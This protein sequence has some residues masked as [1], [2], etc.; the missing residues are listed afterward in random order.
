MHV[1][2]FDWALGYFFPPLGKPEWKA[3]LLAQAA[4]GKAL[5]ALLLFDLAALALGAS[6]ARFMRFRSNGGAMGLAVT[7]VLGYAAAGTA[8]AAV[9]LAGLAYPSVYA[10]L[11]LLGLAFLLRAPVMR[12]LGGAGTALR[13]FPAGVA[14]PALVVALGGLL[15]ALAP[16][17]TDDALRL[18]LGVP[19]R[20]LLVHRLVADPLTPFSFVPLLPCGVNLPLVALS[21]DLPARLLN[22]QAWLVVGLVVFERVSRGGNGARHGAGRLVGALAATAW[23]ALLNVPAVAQT[24]MPDCLLALAVTSALVSTFPGA[25]PAVA[26]VLWGCALAT[27]YQ[28]GFF[29]AGACAAL[30][31]TRPRALPSLAGFAL[32]PVFPWLARNWLE[33]G[34]P[35]APLWMSWT[36]GGGVEAVP[37]VNPPARQWAASRGPLAALAAPFNLVRRP[38][39][40]DSLFP[41][42]ILALLPAALAFARPRAL[43]AALGVAALLWAWFTGNAARY[44]LPAFPLLVAEGVGGV[45]SFLSAGASRAR[46]GVFAGLLGVLVLYEAVLSFGWAFL[47]FNPAGVSEG[48]ESRERYLERMLE[49]RPV[50]WEAMR[51]FATMIPASTRYHVA[52]VL[53]ARYWPG[54]PETD[55]EGMVSRPLLLARG[56]ADEGRLMVAFRQ[57]GWKYLVVRGGFPELPGE[58]RPDAGAAGARAT[59]LLGSFTARR[60][61]LALKVSAAGASF[62]A[63]ELP[64]RDPRRGR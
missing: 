12:V 35:L 4:N 24:A 2:R 61:R 42:L 10:A 51:R 15:G 46:A 3:V 34:T 40:W 54:L 1:P 20:A 55:G 59:D 25:S 18:Y 33:A 16:E 53:S 22:W 14:V 48:R 27:K 58:L 7:L 9:A 47:I 23:L 64:G 63:F 43:G 13:G 62:S 36:P 50:A 28:A 39:Y 41:P 49:P 32:L 6:L 52:G 21:G 17:V 45:A 31:V 44:L 30:A 38:A 8:G 29:L 19:G 57:R 60:A 56:S 5:G 26:G 11:G 37:A